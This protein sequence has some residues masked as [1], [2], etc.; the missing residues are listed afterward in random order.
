MARPARAKTAVE[1]SDVIK[2]LHVNGETGMPATKFIELI[3]M[4]EKLNPGEQIVRAR[5]ITPEHIGFQVT[6]RSGRVGII[7][8]VEARPGAHLVN[9]NLKTSYHRY[10]ALTVVVDE[11]EFC[12]DERGQDFGPRVMIIID[13]KITRVHHNQLLVLSETSG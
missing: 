1:I 8:D 4:I 5:D 11:D 3:H 6:T 7:T 2:A 12:E 9:N 13:G 10:Q